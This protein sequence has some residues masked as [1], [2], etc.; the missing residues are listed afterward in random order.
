MPLDPA[1]FV[2]LDRF[3][4]LD[5]VGAEV[6]H[7]VSSSGDSQLDAWRIDVH[8]QFIDHETG[9]GGYI[10]A[11]AAR[12]ESHDRMADVDAGLMYK[13]ELADPSL[14]LVIHAGLGLPSSTTR[15]GE[16]LADGMLTRV[17]DT[18]LAIPGG[19]T[20]RAGASLVWDGH[21][22]FAR[23]DGAID[24]NLDA[25]GGRADPIGRAGVGFGFIAGSSAIMGELAAARA[26]GQWLST[27]ALAI[28][29]DAGPVQAYGAIE[30]GVDGAT[31]DRMKDAFLLGIDVPFA[32]PPVHHEAPDDE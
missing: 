29:I 12:L 18:A 24:A 15:S 30:F 7:Y 3:D 28:R 8:G 5:R 9:V 6:A 21:G 10:T 22:V 11:P 19:T 14:G 25:I 1:H 26:S 13:P 31:R 16:V 2:T 27:A 32:P 17:A 20:L 4:D 23:G